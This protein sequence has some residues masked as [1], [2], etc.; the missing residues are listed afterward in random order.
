VRFEVV[1]IIQQH[2]PL[3]RDLVDVQRAL[4]ENDLTVGQRQLIGRGYYQRNLPLIDQ[5]LSIGF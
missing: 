4:L 1:F 5:R 3:W 2:R